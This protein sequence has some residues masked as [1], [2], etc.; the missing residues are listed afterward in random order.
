MPHATS[1][2]KL[3]VQ[4]A[5]ECRQLNNFETVHT[6]IQCL[7]LNAISRLSKTW[8]LLNGTSKKLFTSLSNLVHSRMRWK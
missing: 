3:F 8:D 7:S 2:Q 4:I 1:L 6:I 5:E